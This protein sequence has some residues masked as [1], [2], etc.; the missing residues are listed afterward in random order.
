VSPACSRTA[1]SDAGRATRRA[2]TRPDAAGHARQGVM[3]VWAAEMPVQAIP[4]AAPVPCRARRGTTLRTKP[5]AGNSDRS[6]R[7]SGCCVRLC[8][9]GLVAPSVCWGL[10]WRT[11]HRRGRRRQTGD[12][13]TTYDRNDRSR[14]PSDANVNGAARGK[15]ACTRR[16]SWALLAS[17]TKGWQAS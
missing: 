14:P 17:P 4:T 9:V 6:A 3:D 16:R 15:A 1:L 8:W 5:S 2:D 12:A 13:R 7:T 10:T 11:C